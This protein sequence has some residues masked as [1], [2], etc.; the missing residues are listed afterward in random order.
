MAF[1][2][3]MIDTYFINLSSPK[4]YGSRRLMNL[5]GAFGKAI[6]RFLPE[7]DPLPDNKKRPGQDVFDVFYHMDSWA[8]ILDVLRNEKPVYFHYN[9]TNNF[10]QIYTGREPV[11][12][13]ES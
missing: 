10:A 8:A 1:Y 3:G 13:E 2:F 7:G 11:G 4:P 12:E 6:L 9:D 5:N